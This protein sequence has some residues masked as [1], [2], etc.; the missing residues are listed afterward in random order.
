MKLDKEDWFNIIIIILV[1]AM[2]I[3]FIYGFII[4]DRDSLKCLIDPISYKEYITN[5]TCQ[6]TSNDISNPFQYRTVNY[7]L[8]LTG[9]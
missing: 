4:Y 7:S 1:V 5:V 2:L 9:K 3:T 8:S 6:C